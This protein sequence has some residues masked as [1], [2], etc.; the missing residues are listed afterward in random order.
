MTELL[1]IYSKL[2]TQVGDYTKLGDDGI[3]CVSKVTDLSLAEYC[4]VRTQ[5]CLL[6]HDQQKCF[7]C[8]SL[9]RAGQMILSDG[10]CSLAQVF[11]TAFPCI[12]YHSSHAKQRLL[13]MP[14]AV[15]RVGAP[16]SGRSELLV[17]ELVQGVDYQKLALFLNARCSPTSTKATPNLTKCELKQLLSFSQSDRERES[18]RFAVYKASGLSVTAARKLW[19]LENMTE[20]VKRV[21]ECIEE[22]HSIRMCIEDLAKARDRAVLHSYGITLSGDESSDDS[23]SSCES[24]DD[25]FYQNQPSLPSDTPSLPPSDMPSLPSDEVI[26]K[27]LSESQFNWLEFLDRFDCDESS[28]ALEQVFSKLMEATV[29]NVHQKELLQQSHEA[30]LL[31]NALRRPM[32][33]RE[34]AAMNGMIVQ[35]S[36]QMIPKHTFN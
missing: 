34:A 5:Y 28:E 25:T 11:K 31:D 21:T 14:V 24:S 12:D 10:I 17:M 35:D 29:L 6:R 9:V 4:E 33:E 22:T 8:R 1:N 3:V 27:V 20:R 13:Q 18:I 19:G 7:E 15:F 30:Y 23:D 32:D 16:T 2:S 26:L 36:I